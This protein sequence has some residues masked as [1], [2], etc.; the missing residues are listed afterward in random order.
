MRSAIG[1]IKTLINILL[2]KRHQNLSLGFLTMY[3]G[4]KRY[5]GQI[6][7]IK[8]F[9]NSKNNNINKILSDTFA[10]HCTHSCL[11]MP[12][13]IIPHSENYPTYK[14]RP[15]KHIITCCIIF[16]T[17]NLTWCFFFLHVSLF[18]VRP[19]E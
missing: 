19:F 16:M 6:M 1:K 7:C 3:L 8:Y 10:S 5:C 11:L 12:T 9:S 2:I 14:F 18:T 4:S 17:V 13:M 15:Y